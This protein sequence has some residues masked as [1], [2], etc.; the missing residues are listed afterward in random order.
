[1][2]LWR[3]T[4]VR[5]ATRALPALLVCVLMLQGGPAS[6]RSIGAYDGAWGDGFNTI[7]Y[8][9]P[10][11]LQAPAQLPGNPALYAW[12][13]EKLGDNSFL[14]VGPSINYQ[15]APAACGN[16][17]GIW[18]QTQDNSGTIIQNFSVCGHPGDHVFMCGRNNQLPNG[19]WQWACYIDNVFIALTPP[20]NALAGDSGYHTPYAVLEQVPCTGCGQPDINNA[21]PRTDFFPAMAIQNSTTNGQWRGAA[22]GIAYHDEDPAH[23]FYWLCPT[24]SAEPVGW[25]YFYAANTLAPCQGNGVQLW[26]P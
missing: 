2:D 15:W 9:I 20:L 18:M 19:W 12:I 24:Q 16:A 4:W 1:V 14:Q 26:H 25:N 23:G 17:R 22:Y 13:G 11:G 6:A 3:R 8:T 7:F 5:R 21:M 10:R